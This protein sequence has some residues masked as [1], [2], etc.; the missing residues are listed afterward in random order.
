MMKKKP[1]VHPIIL[2]T[3]PKNGKEAIDVH[4]SR[5][6]RSKRWLKCHELGTGV[7]IAVCR[8]CRRED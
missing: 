5:C 7:Y 8:D 1:P 3:P 6:Y 2:G 4:C